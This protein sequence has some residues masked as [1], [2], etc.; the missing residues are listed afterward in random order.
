MTGMR[1]KEHKRDAV[2]EGREKCSS[3]LLC[4]DVKMLTWK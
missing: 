1:E 3:Q 2:R 4:K